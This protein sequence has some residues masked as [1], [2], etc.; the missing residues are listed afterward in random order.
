MNDPMNQ[1]FK[2]IENYVV[3]NDGEWKADWEDY[4]QKKYILCFEVENEWFSDYVTTAN[5][6]EVCMSYE[7]AE[8][9]VKILNKE[10]KDVFNDD[11]NT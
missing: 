2:F 9:L 11:P 5:S 3:H 8:K 6:R 7:C 4:G 1:V 10:Y